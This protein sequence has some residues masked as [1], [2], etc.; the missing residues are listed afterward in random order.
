[1]KSKGYKY[2]YDDE[3]IREYMKVPV[4]EKFRW[5]DEIQ[6]FNELVMPEKTKKIREKLRRGVI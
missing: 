4:W 6:R 1:M 2:Y 3:K 5:L